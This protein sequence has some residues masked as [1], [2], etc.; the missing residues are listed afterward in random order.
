MDFAHRA[1]IV[2]HGKGGKDRVLMLPDSLAPDLRKQIPRA[3]IL[4]VAD[5]AA[6]RAGVEMPD[7][8]E[9]K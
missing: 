6:G 3:H 7:A 5:R 8:I 9:R 4:W 1:V 2:S